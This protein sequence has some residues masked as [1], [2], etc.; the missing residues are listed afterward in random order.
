MVCLVCAVCQICISVLNIIHIPVLCQ[1]LAVAIK[2]LSLIV[3]GR[4]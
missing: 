1:A 3:L 4:G 2:E